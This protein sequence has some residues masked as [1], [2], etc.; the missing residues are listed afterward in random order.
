MAIPAAAMREIIPMPAVLEPALSGH[1][2]L[3]GTVSLR[4]EAIPVIDLGRLPGMAPG[5]GNP[6]T[7]I[8]V[9][10]SGGAVL[11][12]GLEA[13]N[14]LTRVL[15]G[16][17]AAVTHGDGS[18]GDGTPAILPRLFVRNGETIG[19]LDPDGLVRLPGMVSVVEKPPAAR[20]AV[21][22]ETGQMLGLEACGLRL[23]VDSRLV[24]VTFAAGQLRP[25]D[26]PVPGW[27][28]T[29]DYLGQEFP[30]FDDLSV[31]G[32]PGRA[33]GSG[34]VL[35]LRIGA[36]LV[37]WRVDRLLGVIPPDR[38]P[39]HP[40][41]GRPADGGY[42]LFHG[43]LSHADWGD[44]LIVD[45]AAVEGSADLAQMAQLWRRVE[46]EGSA[47]RARRQSGG[48]LVFRSLGRYGAIRLDEI[49]AVRR[50]VGLTYAAG[51]GEGVFGIVTD[52]QG[53][54]V[55]AM[56]FGQPAPADPAGRLILLP[57]AERPGLCVEALCLL[58]HGQT[59]AAR[60]DLL[61][62]C[63]DEVVDG[64]RRSVAIL[65]FS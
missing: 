63:L 34:P 20:R 18:Q 62:D 10:R 59:I 21:A 25:A 3:L 53:S 64:V 33:P 56:P 40:L 5:A 54:A 45:S 28:W 50:M 58:S 26:V 38:H 15:P 8:G 36:G 44:M 37:G 60:H 46:A 1:P 27:P 32:M 49:R 41:A 30:V 29:A 24:T 2:A 11:G 22:A 4:G 17:M 35:A 19:I 51:A 52:A 14:G 65:D 47:E 9:I 48:H 31:L 57:R 7:A 43:I 12:V 6:M 55:V 13:V 42:G 61:P 16:E 39:V 23:A